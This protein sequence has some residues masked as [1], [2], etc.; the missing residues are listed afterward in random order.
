MQITFTYQFVI[1]GK[2]IDLKK[3]RTVKQINY[4]VQN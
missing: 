2:K 1:F 4:S 3:K